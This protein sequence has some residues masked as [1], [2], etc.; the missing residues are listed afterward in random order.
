MWA[1]SRQLQYHC[2]DL[3]ISVII[4]NTVAVII[5]DTTVVAVTL[6]RTQGTWRLYKSSAW[7]SKPS[8]NLLAQQSKSYRLSRP[9]TNTLLQT[10]QASKDMG[11]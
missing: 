9:F 5:F 7:H 1:K 11:K 10:W 4:I 2:I 6:A 3:P 8:T